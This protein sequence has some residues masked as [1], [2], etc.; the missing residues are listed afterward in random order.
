[1]RDYIDR[2]VNRGDADAVGELVAPGYTGHG[3]GWP[4]D[5]EALREFYAHQARARPDWRIDVQETLEVGEWVAVRAHAGDASRQ[6][7]WLALYRV[8]DD[9]VAEIRIVALEERDVA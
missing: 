9:R 3:H 5:R 4:A 7:E 8:D 6:V 1:M 2:V